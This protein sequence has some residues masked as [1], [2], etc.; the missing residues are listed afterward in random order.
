MRLARP[1]RAD[2]LACEFTRLD[3]PMVLARFA[4]RFNPLL[5]DLLHPLRYYWVTDQVEYATGV[6]FR[7]RALEAASISG[8]MR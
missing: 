4:R 1:E 3:W 7:S 8:P 5:R 6:M 2:R